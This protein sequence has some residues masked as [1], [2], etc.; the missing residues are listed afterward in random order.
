MTVA[1]YND[2]GTGAYSDESGTATGWRYGTYDADYAVTR[3]CESGTGCDSCGTKTGTEDGTVS[4]TCYQW[5]RT[6]STS[7]TGLA[8][9]FDTN[10]NEA[11]STVWNGNCRDLEASCSD[12]WSNVT[13]TGTFNGVAYTGFTAYL[14]G[15]YMYKT[16][17][18]TGGLCAA[19]CDAG[20]IYE[21]FRAYYC[22]TTATYRV[23]NEGCI[24]GRG[25]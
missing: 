25:K 3:A 12:S 4:R 17:C 15:Y 8:C 6:G 16:A 11:Q 13:A 7:E 9:T 22:T 24:D 21:S 14:G 2:N 10:N 5:T 18:P 20:T 23:T 19:A 1:A